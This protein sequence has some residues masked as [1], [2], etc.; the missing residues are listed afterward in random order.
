MKIKIKQLVLA[1]PPNIV[2]LTFSVPFYYTNLIFSL[3]HLNVRNFFLFPVSCI[4]NSFCGI[5]EYYL[6][7]LKTVIQSDYLLPFMITL[8]PFLSS[9]FSSSSCFFVMFFILFFILTSLYSSYSSSLSSSSS[10]HHLDF[11][12][13]HIFFIILV[14]FLFVISSLSY[15]SS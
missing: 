14:F 3:L 12:L 13:R 8:F 4:Y 1:F 2:K 15:S 9:F 5:K 11:L 6:E 7:I 10:L